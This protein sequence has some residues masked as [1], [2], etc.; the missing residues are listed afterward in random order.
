AILLTFQIIPLVL[1]FAGKPSTYADL[2]LLNGKIVTVD[3]HFTIAK[4]VAIRQ[5]KIIAVGSDNEIRKF[6]GSKTKVIDLAGRTV[7]PGLIDFHAH[8]DGAAVSEL[9]QQI[10]DVHTIPE[11]LDWIKDQASIKKQ[12]EWIIHPKLFFTRLKELRQPSLAELDSVAPH[13]PVFLNGSYGGMINSA[14]IQASA[15]TT[16]TQNPGIVRDKK[17]GLLTGFIRASAFKLLKL[18]PQ[19]SLSREQKLKAFQVMLKRYNQY[20][21]TSVCS[22]AGNKELFSVYQD[23]NKQNKLTTRIFQNILVNTS[24][25]MTVKTLIDTLKAFTYVTGD[26]DAMVRI[27]A[28]KITLDG[29]ILTGTAYMREP[30]GDKAADIFGI[31]DTT[32]RGV[33]N[34]SREDLLAIVKV[35]NELNW[36]FTA[37]C[38]GGGGVDLLLDVFEEVNR[39]KPIKERRFSIIHGNFFT[40]EAIRRMSELGVCADM[41]PAWFYKDADAMEYI[42]GDKRIETFHPYRSLIDAGVIVNGGSDHMVKLDANTSVNPYNPFLAMWA[43]VART[44]ERGNVIVPS[45]A[46]SREQ[47]LKMYT[48]NNAYGSFEESLKGSIESGKLADMVILTDDLLTCPVEQIKNIQSELTLLGG[49]I[50]YS[51][52]LYSAGKII[53]KIRK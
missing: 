43:V 29:G 32:Y 38:T 2:I 13:H 47:A 30:W 12:G 20:G 51:S 28:L 37:H 26:G 27:G 36:K 34:Y 7:V 41:Q 35:A 6:A 15:I 39:L 50:V 5:D 19:K 16:E 52:S 9:D 24:S 10:P 40:K 33:V 11:L 31:D 17:T 14:A 3:K 49:K 48:I 23:L 46:I 21:I 4:A 18:P 8:P 44:T 1:L 42:L 45:E 53:K 22:G 25:S